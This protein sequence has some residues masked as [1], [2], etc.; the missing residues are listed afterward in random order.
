M[1]A[2]DWN[3]LNGRANLSVVTAAEGHVI[4]ARQVVAGNLQ[5]HWRARHDGVL[6][7]S[8]LIYRVAGLTRH[9]NGTPQS[10]MQCGGRHPCKQRLDFLRVHIVGKPVMVGSTPST[11]SALQRADVEFANSA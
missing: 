8:P 5:R 9:T 11:K 2:I 7:N 6:G 1:E 3:V 10:M 4:A